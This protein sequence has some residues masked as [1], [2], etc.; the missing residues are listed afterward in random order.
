VLFAADS[1]EGITDETRDAIRDL[2]GGQLFDAE[3]RLSTQSKRLPGT[4]K[5][6]WDDGADDR[7]FVDYAA[8]LDETK[9]RLAIRAGGGR[10][11]S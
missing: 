4:R 7:G 1:R 5:T 6:A 11:R 10:K 9:E 2:H 8:I 3:I